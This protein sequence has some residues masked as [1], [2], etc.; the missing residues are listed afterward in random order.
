VKYPSGQQPEIDIYMKEMFDVWH[1]PYILTNIIG[2]D[3]L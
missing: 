1:T 3:K 2:E